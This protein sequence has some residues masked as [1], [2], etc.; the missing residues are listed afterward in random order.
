MV[1]RIRW[2]AALLRA[3]PRLFASGRRTLITQI[4]LG[5]PEEGDASVHDY[6]LAAECHWAGVAPPD[7]E[8]L[9]CSGTFLGL[10]VE[11]EGA[12]YWGWLAASSGRAVEQLRR[13]TG[14]GTYQGPC[15]PMAKAEDPGSAFVRGA[16][17]AR[18]GEHWRAG[19]GEWVA[20]GMP[21]AARVPAGRTRTGG[22]MG[23]AVEAKIVAHLCGVAPL[24]PGQTR[25][26]A[27]E[28]V[29][30]MLRYWTPGDPA[31]GLWDLQRD[32]GAATPEERAALAAALLD[33]AGA[34]EGLLGALAG[35]YWGA[36]C[37]WV[38]QRRGFSWGFMEPYRRR[39]AR[40]RRRGTGPPGLAPWLEERGSVPALLRDRWI[41]RAWQ[42]PRLGL[43]A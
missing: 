15:G 8:A 13:A 21:G 40:G 24:A 23:A 27:L 32:A 34:A 17:R 42:E 39:A 41:R 31:R 5:H 30:P 14:E 36:V 25:R 6:R 10:K 20:V 3:A 38:I 16:A 37:A 2:T 43:A 7:M 28:A 19:G 22:N 35:P 18:F 33:L 11:R 26:A 4:L 1:A 9:W 29:L 12:A